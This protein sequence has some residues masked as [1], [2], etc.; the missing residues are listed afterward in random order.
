[1]HGET[2]LHV[3]AARHDVGAWAVMRE[4]GKH[5]GARECVMVL[6][7]LSA[8]ANADAT[9]ARG[10]TPLELALCS[11]RAGVARLLMVAG[12]ALDPAK[13]AALASAGTCI[14]FLEAKAAATTSQPPLRAGVLRGILEAAT[15]A[16]RFDWLCSTRLW[17]SPPLYEEDMCILLTWATVVAAGGHRVGVLSTPLD[18]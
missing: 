2:P 5:D 11:D 12:A 18:Y 4:H 14:A 6:A 7:L 8:G 16:P 9:D 17:N 10:R 15:T 13:L 1:V 3:T